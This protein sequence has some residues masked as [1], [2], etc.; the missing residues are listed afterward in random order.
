MMF[1]TWCPDCEGE[2]EATSTLASEASRAA[3][4]CAEEVWQAGGR[5]NWTATVICVRDESGELSKW[6]VS[7]E[8]EISFISTRAP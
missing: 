5:G 2:D 6:R 7:A 8:T 4:I 1:K 3:E